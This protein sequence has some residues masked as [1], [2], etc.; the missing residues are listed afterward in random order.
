MQASGGAPPWYSGPPLWYS[1]AP[2]YSGAA[3]TS[4]GSLSPFAT[5]TPVP[6]IHWPENAKYH[7]VSFGTT[8]Y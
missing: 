7:Q 5:V 3:A 1:G 2:L 6:Q 4:T 8:K